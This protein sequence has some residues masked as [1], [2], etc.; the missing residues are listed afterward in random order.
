MF[1]LIE[2]IPRIQRIETPLE[3]DL[4]WPF[5]GHPLRAYF[6][7]CKE[8]NGY[9]DSLAKDAKDT[10]DLGKYFIPQSLVCERRNRTSWIGLRRPSRL[11]VENRKR[12]G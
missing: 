8:A 5:R 10:K 6:T 4:L 12:K 3:P 1:T 7:S 2:Q 9:L 11:G